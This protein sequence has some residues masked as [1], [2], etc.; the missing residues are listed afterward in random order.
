MATM[1]QPY[2]PYPPQVRYPHRDASPAR[3]AWDLVTS[4]VLALMLLAGCGLGWLYSLFAGMATDACSGTER[5][6]FDLIDRAYRV[7]WGGI[8]VALAVTLA[9]MI[10]AW[11]RRRITF[12]WP[13][14]GWVIFVSTYVVGG[15]LL[16]A[17]VGL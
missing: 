13:L 17:G 8:G 14:L 7:A 1:V 10:I 2:P 3:P 12:I 11:W 4:A 16:N 5:C 15:F 9:G 6:S